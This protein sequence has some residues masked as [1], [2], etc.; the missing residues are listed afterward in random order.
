[1]LN[2]DCRKIVPARIPNDSI[3]ICRDTTVIIPFRIV[4]I[5]LDNAKF[6]TAILETEARQLG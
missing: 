6:N 4:G 1:M 5:V 3:I 2:N